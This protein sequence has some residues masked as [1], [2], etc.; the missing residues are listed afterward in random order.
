[1]ITIP[2]GVRVFL[3]SRPVDF[4]KQAFGLAALVQMV[5]AADPMAGDVYVFRSRGGDRVKLLTHDG[6]G[7]CLYAKVLDRGRF[8]WPPV[9]DG[10]IVLSPAQLALLLEGLSWQQVIPRQIIR[11]LAAC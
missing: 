7:L 10:V 1:M 5:L 4:R 8:S 11:P 6:T 2:A 9:R 3:A